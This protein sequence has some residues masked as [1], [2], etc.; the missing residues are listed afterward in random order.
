MR[1]RFFSIIDRD[2]FVVAY[3]FVNSRKKPAKTQKSWDLN[4][5]FWLFLLVIFLEE[6]LRL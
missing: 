6:I 5:V 4:T 1:Q 3:S 2:T